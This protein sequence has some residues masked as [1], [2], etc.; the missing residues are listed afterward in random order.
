VSRAKDSQVG[1]LELLLDTICNTFGGV[2]FISML[3]VVLLNMTSRRVALEPPTEAAQAE[4]IECRQELAESR[5]EKTRLQAA[6][7][8]QEK[9]AAQILDPDLEDLARQLAS[10]RDTRDRLTDSKDKSLE[11]IG[12][13]QVGVNEIARELK[14]LDDQMRQA[15]QKLAAV[16][17]R[18]QE[19]ISARTRTA[20]LPTPRMTT[21]AEIPWFLRGGRLSCYAKPGPNGSLVPNPAECRE[22][23]DAKNK[24]YIE[25][26]SGAGTPVDPKGDRGGAI[27][28]RLSAFDKDQ[29]Y[30]AV[31]VSPDSFGH[32]ATIRNA[33]VR[34]QFEYRL[35]PIPDGLKIYVAAGNQGPTIVQ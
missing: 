1:S 11:E 19:E 35:V 25:P 8:Q 2:L 12:Q 31:F 6:V 4:L 14:Q 21:K 22:K 27:A 28:A 7:K 16:D 9:T 18:L 20:K 34:L 23:K 26:I 13:S 33:M 3:V 29:H 24:P 10:R 30:L 5:H 32:F 15:R 17:R